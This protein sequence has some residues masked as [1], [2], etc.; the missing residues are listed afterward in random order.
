MLDISQ[1]AAKIIVP[2]IGSGLNSF[3]SAKHLS[4]WTGMW[5]SNKEPCGKCLSDKIRMGNA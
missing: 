2:M 1:R 4:S 5:P 3:P